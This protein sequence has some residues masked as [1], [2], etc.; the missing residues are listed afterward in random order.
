MAAGGT[1]TAGR[2]KTA[3]QRAG[4]AGRKGGAARDAI[5]RAF[6]EVGG[7]SALAEWATA[8]EDNRKIFYSTLYPKLLGAQGAGA[9]EL[10]TKPI[11]EIRRTI[12]YP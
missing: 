3:A 1:K 5:A 9:G 6:D 4:R 10:E 2:A 7:V 11:R 12:V 8:N